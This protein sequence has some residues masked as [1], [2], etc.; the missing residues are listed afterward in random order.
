MIRP[1]RQQHENCGLLPYGHH[2]PGRDHPD[3]GMSHHRKCSQTLIVTPQE[4]R[5]Y[6]A[7]SR[8][9]TLGTPWGTNTCKA[10]HRL[11]MLLS[12]WWRLREW[13]KQS[14]YSRYA[15]EFT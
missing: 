10:R 13:R 1:S 8:P 7:A 15:S 9:H 11:D 2:R 4:K 12:Y 6:Q 3:S 14:D 5:S